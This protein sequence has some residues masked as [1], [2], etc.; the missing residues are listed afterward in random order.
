MLSSSVF[1]QIGP[2]STYQNFCGRVLDV[3][4]VGQLAYIVQFDNPMNGYQS[5][6]FA[7]EVSE[8]SGT[9]CPAD[10]D[11]LILAIDFLP[12]P[13]AMSMLR[14]L[15]WRAMREP[16]VAYLGN[17]VR[18]GSVWMYRRQTDGSDQL[19]ARLADS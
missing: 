1:T 18:P 10:P 4:N 8:W 16:I 6:T 9:P 15:P 3:L 12:L 13:E 7:F 11:N 2:D 14:D 17:K 5:L 19:I